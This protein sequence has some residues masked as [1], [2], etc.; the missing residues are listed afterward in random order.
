MY[1]KVNTK[2]GKQDLHPLARPGDWFGK[3]VQ[4]VGMV[5][6]RDGNGLISE[7]GLLRRCKEYFEGADEWRE[8]EQ[9]MKTDN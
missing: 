6:V 4:L 5:K 2:K 1:V 3:H 9:K 8:N 7:E